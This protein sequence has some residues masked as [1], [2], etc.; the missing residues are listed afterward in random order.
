M[1]K[2]D[3][4]PLPA[5]GAGD[6]TYDAAMAPFFQRIEMYNCPAFP[7]DRQPVDFVMN[8]WDLNSPDGGKTGSF[9]KITSLRRSAE[10]LLMT[11]ANQNRQINVFEYH[12]VWD[13]KHLPLASE[14]RVCND[15]RHKGYVNC[16][17][18]DGHAEPRSFKE[19]RKEDFWLGR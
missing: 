15:Q 11:E 19:L 9:L 13:P 1:M 17:Y 7:D 14:P 5:S 6:A 4:P 10:L 2:Y 12:D 8:G 18:V 3:M 16:L